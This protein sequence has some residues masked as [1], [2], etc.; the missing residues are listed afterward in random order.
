MFFANDKYGVR[1]CID[2]ASTSE[3]YTCPICKCDMIQ[4][5]GRIV[6]PHFAHKARRDCDSWYTGKM[7][8]WHKEM[9]ELFPKRCREIP[10]WDM[11]HNEYHIADAVFSKGPKRWVVEFQHSVI[12]SGDFIKRTEFYIRCGYEVIWIFDFINTKSPKKL[13]YTQEQDSQWIKVVW[14]GQ[15]RVRF[16]EDIDFEQYEGKVSIYF[17]ISTGKGRAYS[18]ESYYY[19]TW[20]RW[21]YV[22]PFHREHLFVELNLLNFDSLREFC[23]RPYPEEKFYKMLKQAGKQSGRIDLW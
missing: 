22:D 3:T 23:A 2:D 13:Y 18:V 7:S 8:L 5:R 4:K 6:T 20:E 19:P 21:E 14:P 11:E 9:Q 12:S 15:D 10:I 1:I 17:Y 16:L